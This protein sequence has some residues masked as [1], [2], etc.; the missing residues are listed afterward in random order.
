MHFRICRGHVDAIPL[1]D[2]HCTLPASE[3]TLHCHSRL[4]PCLL[5]GACA[6]AGPPIQPSSARPQKR[7]PALLFL[8]IRLRRTTSPIPQRARSSETDS[9]EVWQLD[10]IHRPARLDCWKRKW[11]NPEI[12]SSENFQTVFPRSLPS[13]L[14]FPQRPRKGRKEGDGRR[15]CEGG[16][17]GCGRTRQ[18][19]REAGVSY[20]RVPAH[21]SEVAR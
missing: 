15:E 12:R 13:L 7:R 14:P 20:K 16:R 1:S 19:C 10:W 18:N 8:F 4:R 21:S 2:C 3:R 9:G 5:H 6:S 11:D 17:N